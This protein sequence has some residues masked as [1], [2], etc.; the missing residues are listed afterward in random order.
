MMLLLP[1]FTIVI[2]TGAIYFTVYCRM[3]IAEFCKTVECPSSQIF[4]SY[5]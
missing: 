5:M 1:V 4:G 2:G 3:E